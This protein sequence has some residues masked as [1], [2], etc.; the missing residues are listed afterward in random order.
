MNLLNNPLIL[1][2]S[3]TYAM[4]GRDLLNNMGFRAYLERVSRSKTTGCGYGIYVPNRTDEAEQ[5]LLG[6]GFRILG[7]IERGVDMQ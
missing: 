4:K 3:V 5:V 1:V 6:E 7:R 2:S